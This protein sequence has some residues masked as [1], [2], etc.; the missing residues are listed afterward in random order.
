MLFGRYTNF[1]RE[2]WAVKNVSFSVKKGETLGIVGVNG[3]GKSTLLQMISG[4]LNPTLGGL[5]VNGRVSALLELGS[6]FNPEFTGKEN[7]Y[8]NASILGLSKDEIEKRYDEILAFADIGDF[9]NQPVKT[10]SSGMVMR[11]AFSVAINVDPDIFIVDEALAV[12]DPAFQAKCMQKFEVFRKKGV[13]I[14]IVSH[15]LGTIL[16]FSDRCILI[17]KGEILSMSDPKRV[18]DEFK[19]ILLGTNLKQIKSNP[20]SKFS[21]RFEGCEVSN[22]YLNY[23]INE[24]GCEIYGNSKVSFLDFGIFDS[25]GNM[26]NQKLSTGESYTFKMILKF[27]SEVKDPIFSLTIRDLTG[28]EIVGTNTMLE[29]VVTGSFGSGSKVEVSFKT[30]LRLAPDNYMLTFACSG[31]ENNNFVVYERLYHILILEV[32]SKKTIV[33]YYDMDAEITF[34][35]TGAN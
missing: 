2:F 22:W 24:E 21:S 12:G 5:N 6:G 31:F 25:S 34:K 15:D 30:Y 35:K 29:E 10:Y 23:K 3:S 4:T 28:R 16:Q 19:K 20:S 7:V 9:I 18:V 8:L 11:L 17:D 13:T 33:G 14:V 27:N 26:I 32:Y 1:Y